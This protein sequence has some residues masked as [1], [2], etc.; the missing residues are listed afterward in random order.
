VEGLCASGVDVLRIG[1]GPTPMLYFAEA[2]M[3]QVQGGI[4]ITG[5]HNPADQNGFKIVLEGRPFFGS[6]ILDLGRR[7]AAGDWVSA[8]GS[9]TAKSVNIMGAYV[10]RLT[11]ALEG[12]EPALLHGLADWLGCRQWCSG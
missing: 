11:L 9:G 6:D 8:A 1:I 12:I 2:S 7:A 4:Q 10:D 3:E 5:S